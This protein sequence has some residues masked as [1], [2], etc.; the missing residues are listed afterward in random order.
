[1]QSET[2]CFAFTGDTT[3]HDNFWNALN[4]HDKLDLLICEVAF[5]NSLEDLAR[6]AGHYSPRLLAEDLAK[7]R[8]VP[9]I[10]LSHPKPGQEAV[11]LGEC[12]ESIPD[13]RM[14]ML[15]HNEEFSF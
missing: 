5:P 12:R 3:N 8:H 13:R 9:K 4:A 1:V 2:G 6:R 10:C 7:L 14:R 15:R 11:I